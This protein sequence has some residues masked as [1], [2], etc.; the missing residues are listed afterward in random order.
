M[1]LGFTISWAISISVLFDRCM[2]RLI[3]IIVMSSVLRLPRMTRNQIIAIDH[4]KDD[5]VQF[6][7]PIDIAL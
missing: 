5:N 7:M 1:A 2:S 3:I 6:K 4:R